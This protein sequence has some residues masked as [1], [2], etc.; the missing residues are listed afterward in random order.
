MTDQ[1]GHYYYNGPGATIGSQGG[2]VIGGIH[3]GTGAGDYPARSL[4]ELLDELR[5][6]VA[7]ASVAGRID[8]ATLGEANAALA[9]AY[10]HADAT[11]DT[12][13]GTLLGSLRK[14][15]RVLTNVSGLAGSIAAVISAIE[16]IR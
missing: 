8:D 13:R 12:S 10:A 5:V 9:V 16:G 6:G 3:L 4:K 11:D 1:M 2:S 7:E 14:A 15:M